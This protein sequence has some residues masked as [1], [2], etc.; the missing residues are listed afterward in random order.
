MTE[1]H[2]D[3]S[4]QDGFALER[5]K[6]IHRIEAVTDVRDP[7]ILSAFL[8]VP[9]HLF[10]PEGQRTSAY[11]D[12]AL[13]LVEMQTISQPSMI[14]IMLSALDCSETDHVLEVGAGS[15]Y[16]AALLGRL[17]GRVDAIELRPRLAA[18]ARQ[19]LR[20]IGAQNV[21]IHVG[22]G[23][24]G[25]P[26]QAPFG[27]ILVSAGA[28]SVPTALV[29]QLRV[30]GRIAIPVGQAD[31]QTLLVGERT[32]DSNV[33]WVQSIPCMFVPLILS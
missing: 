20:A 8:S 14:A 18:K 21:R 19:T 6:L 24:Q 23:S 28:R 4:P 31:S 17:A 16:A 32:S 13:P 1:L 29:S 25:L 22:D 11:E 3:P 15:G 2:R 5:E 27:K 33:E 30:G 9:R 10:I 12:R 26:E 7:R